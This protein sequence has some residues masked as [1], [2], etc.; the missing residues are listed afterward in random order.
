MIL[1]V[2]LIQLPLTKMGPVP[3]LESPQ[4]VCRTQ[5]PTPIAPPRYER[6]RIFHIAIKRPSRINTQS[7][8]SGTALKPGSGEHSSLPRNP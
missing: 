4:T 7:N 2:N 6:L 3:R 5:A 8:T 1:S